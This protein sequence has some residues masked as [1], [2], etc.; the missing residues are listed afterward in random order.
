MTCPIKRGIRNLHMNIRGLKSKVV[1]VKNIVKEHKPHI[2]GLSECELV[3]NGAFFDEQILKVPGY[4]L[5][6]PSSWR[7]LG[8]ARVV[9][10]IKNGFEYEQLEDLEDDQIQAV[11]LKAGFKWLQRIFFSHFYRE[12]TNTLGNSMAAQRNSLNKF[13]NKWEEATTYNNLNGINEVHLMG[14][15]NLDSLHDNWLRP[16]YS[17]Y[18]LSK[19]VQQACNVSNFSQLVTSPTR[20]QYNSIRKTTSISCI[21]HLY[22]NYRSM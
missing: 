16:S 9:V 8:I 21:D 4:S 12:H 5:V 3:R 22:C 10:Y 20:I 13:L 17:L 1:E 19:L 11:W 6:F 18:S 15:M 14:D 7:T 2:L